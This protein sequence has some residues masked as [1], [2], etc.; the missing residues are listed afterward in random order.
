MRAVTTPHDLRTE[1]SALARLAIPM[2]AATAGQ[3]LMG[4]VDTAVCGRAGAATLGGAGLGNAIF[5]A[6][7]VFGMGT[8]LG[9]EPLVSQAIGAGDAAR[10]RRWLWQG[11]WL[12]LGL[13]AAIAVVLFALWCARLA[14]EP[15]LPARAV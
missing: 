8:V 3:A 7:T 13:G 9:L 4:V 11:A 6:F 15:E 5:F 2:A 14:R 10:A 12:S 1:L